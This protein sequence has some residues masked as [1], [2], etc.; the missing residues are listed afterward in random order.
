MAPTIEPG[1]LHVLH[2]APVSTSLLGGPLYSVVSLCKALSSAGTKTTLATTATQDP[3]M[4]GLDYPIVS[5][6]GLFSTSLDQL[7]E[8]EGKPDLISFH[9]TYIL[10][11]AILAKHAQRLGI[12]YVI[13]PRG[14]MTLGAQRR[15][16]FKKSL[17]NALFF[18]GMVRNAVAIHCLNESE[19]EEART[20][21]VPV[22]VSPNGIDPQT[23]CSPLVHATSSSI[24]FLFLGRIDIEHKGLDR[25]LGAV[26]LIADEFRATKSTVSIYGPHSSKDFQRLRRQISILR[27]GDIV[28][29]PGEVRGDDKTTAFINADCFVHLSRY[30]GHPIAVLEALSHGLP[31]L[32]T[33]ET[34]VSGCV[35]AAG[36]GWEVGGQPED[37]SRVM[38]AIIRDPF[39]ITQMR[40]K[41]IALARN[42][43]D[44]T[45][46]AANL[47]EV[48]QSL[49]REHR[50]LTVA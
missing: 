50:R 26:S 8:R 32:L 36:A 35:L 11:Q 24:R 10:K 5:C 45:K 18:R 16:V 4:L 43:F 21:G 17:A 3:G 44:W 46:I 29:T 23:R 2:I 25:L 42:Q 14:G 34:N 12:P 6:A 30:E 33:R 9:S 37:A 41:A 28:K 49:V 48:Y 19:A 39:Q 1:R 7:L 27:L 40:P 22:F 47:S 31:C 20:W 13:V 15:K 38:Q